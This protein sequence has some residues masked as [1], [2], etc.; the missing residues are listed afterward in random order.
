MTLYTTTYDTHTHIADWCIHKLLTF[1]FVPAL[2][3][4]SAHSFACSNKNRIDARCS[5]YLF[6]YSITISRIRYI[7]RGVSWFRVTTFVCG[8]SQ[9]NNSIVT[10]CENEKIPQQ[11][12]FW[13]SVRWPGGSWTQSDHNIDS[14]L[15]QR[16][17]QHRNST[18]LWF[19]GIVC[20]V[21]YWESRENMKSNC[22]GAHRTH[23][24]THSR[25]TNQTLK[26]TWS[27]KGN[28]QL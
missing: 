17:V 11:S 16:T 6:I 7:L 18:L 8:I 12:D 21:L 27:V 3:M 28:L 9:K 26:I 24:Q 2:R 22:S 13:S 19:C 1:H 4:V 25:E 15:R 5:P 14:D 10:F 23:T 20:R